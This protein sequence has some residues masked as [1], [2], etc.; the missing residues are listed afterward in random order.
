MPEPPRRI[1]ITGAAGFLGSATLERLTAMPGTELVVGIDILPTPG[2]PGETGRFVSV[3]RD[4]TGPLE[5]ILRDYEVDAVVHLA[6]VLRP[7]RDERVARL[8]N[9]DATATLLDACA[10]AGVGRFVYLSSTTVYGAHASYTRPYVETDSPAPVAGFTYSEHKVEAEALIERFT[11]AHPEVAAS[12][13]RGCVIMA[14]GADNFIADSLSMRLLP[15]AAGSDPEMQFLHIDDYASAVEAV[16]VK[17]AVGV[18]N[19]AGSGTVRWRDMVRMAGG[20]VVPVPAGLLRKV[21][22]VTWGLRLQN[23][24]PSSGLAFITYPWLASTAKIESEL[25]WKARH[26]SRDALEAWISG[27]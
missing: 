16:L 7:P 3:V 17:R 18:F 26:S 14:P 8:I 6:F 9:V 24:S 12:V 2:P 4:V 21:I 15:A 20:R 1:A 5:D 19:I 22:D 11:E 23:R 10:A 13:L 27:R 25:G